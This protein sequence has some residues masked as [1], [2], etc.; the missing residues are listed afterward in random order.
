MAEH[1][2]AP[3]APGRGREERV[4]VRIAADDAMENHDVGRLDRLGIDGHVV[5]AALDP[6]LEPGLAR[7]Q[8]SGI[9]VCRRQLEIDR[10]GGARLQQLELQSADTASDLQHRRPVDPARYELVA[11]GAGG[12]VEALATVA[13][14]VAPGDPVGEEL[15]AASSAACG[16]ATTVS[17]EARAAGARRLS[18]EP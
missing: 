5:Q 4:R 11:Q 12:A 2:D 1:E 6:I 18:S 9:V 7:E 3:R 10:A 17:A 15:L 13:A 14:R 8:E 16:H